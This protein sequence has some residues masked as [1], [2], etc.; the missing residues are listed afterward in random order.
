MPRKDIHTQSEQWQP[1]AVTTGHEQSKQ[2]APANQAVGDERTKQ[3]ATSEPSIW[4]ERTKQMATSEYKELGART[5]QL[6]ERTSSCRERMSPASLAAEDEHADVGV[7]VPHS[8]GMVCRSGEQQRR[9]T[10]AEP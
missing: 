9:V 4:G 3:M 8:D 7:D 1:A 2:L 5:K 6:G 10:S